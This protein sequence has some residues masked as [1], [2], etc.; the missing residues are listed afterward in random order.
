MIDELTAISGKDVPA[1]CFRADEGQYIF[2]RS[3]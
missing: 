2:P 1:V 3:T